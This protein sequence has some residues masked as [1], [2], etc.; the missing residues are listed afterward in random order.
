MEKPEKKTPH[1]FND[2]GF[3]LCFIALI[4]CI[5]PTFFLENK[6][7]FA[8][9]VAI[10][11][12]VLII[13]LSASN[14]RRK[15]LDKYI[16]ESVIKQENLSGSLMLSF[17]LPMA[18]ILMENNTVVWA[19]ELFSAMVGT[20]HLY[21][22]P[23]EDVI[24]G[25][26]LSWVTEGGSTCPEEVVFGDKTYSIRGNL[27]SI[28]A[29]GMRGLLSVLY[30]SDRTER[31]QLEETIADGQ[32][33]IA[34]ILWDNYEEIAK[35]SD[36]S[37]RSQMTAQ[38]DEA[39][40]GWVSARD[41]I[42]RKLERDRYMLI[43]NEKAYRA[44]AEENFDILSKV[45]EIAPASGTMAPTITI[46][47]GRGGKTLAETLQAARM[48]SEMALSRGGNQAVVRTGSNYEFFGGR[49]VETER[50]SRVRS[51]I[52]ANVLG[53]LIRDSSNVIIMSH[54]GADPD[55]V[56]A[57]A[58][59]A[60][61]CTELGK[62]FLIVLD[63]HRCGCVR[64][65]EEL[66]LQ[67]GYE[68]AFVDAETA[69]VEGNSR[70]LLV[71][72]DTSSKDYTEAPELCDSFARIAV[73]DHHR[74]S[75]GYIENAAVYIQESAASSTCEM[76]CEM[77]QYVV[78][79]GHLTAQEAT[80]M[81]SG[82]ILDTRGFTVKCGTRAFEAAAFLRRSG[83]DTVGA[84][85]IFQGTPDAYLE[86]TRLAADAEP[87]R[88]RFFIAVTRRETQRAVAAQAADSL[89]DISGAMASFTVFTCEG[90]TCISARSLG[91]VN[92]QII[93]EWLGGGGQLTSA[94]AQLKDVT[95][96]EAAEKLRAAIDRYLEQFSIDN[97]K[98][99]KQK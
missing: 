89:L 24:P 34:D 60:R 71:V 20:S 36:D 21:D 70:S 46:G 65:C 74:R 5:V 84:K 67:P 32:T 11:A 83:A 92:V 85:S 25:M 86:K 57:A 76:V 28:N 19:N 73:I 94:G 59:V 41:G 93:V 7:W 45:M 31:R 56:G 55:S 78:P 95:V 63:R 9:E 1:L 51:R 42:L 15:A 37:A 53:D 4:L 30:F 13:Y 54:R 77:L 80:A 3:R 58:G 90:E 23:I 38:L 17:P 88:G 79:S 50:R 14:K 97:E 62:P 87:Y 47:V 2:S 27:F 52:M 96:E 99:E 49:A 72:V 91:Q 8:I 64:M 43:F 75:A 29:T 6:L 66:E 44:F 61:M 81:L 18:V 35:N 98:Q 26:S 12:V 40:S 22:R 69:L 68:H 82:I 10:A 33:V 16:K 48:A 39:I